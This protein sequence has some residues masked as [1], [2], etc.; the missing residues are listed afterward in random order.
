MYFFDPWF[1]VVLL[2][3][4]MDM[5]AAHPTAAALH[6]VDRYLGLVCAGIVVLMTAVGACILNT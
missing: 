4:D 6:R 3:D 2:R 1:G 5:Q